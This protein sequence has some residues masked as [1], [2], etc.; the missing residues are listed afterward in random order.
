MTAL[1]YPGTILS[2]S[3]IE[4][5]KRACPLTEAGVDG[6]YCRP[7]GRK[8]LNDQAGDVRVIALSAGPHVNKTSYPGFVTKL[9]WRPR[10]W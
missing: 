5:G 8:T 6:N 10:P 4:P 3:E 7:S 2:A 1:L 9:T